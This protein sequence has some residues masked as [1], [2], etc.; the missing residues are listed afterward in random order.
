MALARHRQGA[1]LVLGRPARRQSGAD[2]AD[3]R[4]AQEAACSS[5]WSAW[6]SRRSRSAFPS[7]SQT[8]FDF[9]RSIIERTRSP[10]MSTIQVL[11]QCAAGTDR[12]HLRGGQGR[13]DGHRPLLQ[14]DLDLQRAWCSARTATGIDRHRRERRASRS[15]R[16]PTPMPGTEIVSSNIR[17]RA[18][19]AP[20]SI[21]RVEICE[22][23]M[24]VMAADAGEAADP[25][26]AGD[27]RDGDAE[28][29]R[30]PDRMVRRATSR[31]RDERDPVAS[32]RTTIAAPRSRRP[33]WR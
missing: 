25:Q 22:A 13:Q 33:S 18:S 15:R 23:V 11:T 27:G 10:T 14:L 4:R 24:D 28:H 12:A 6:A 7:A 30:R 5:C 32:I 16:W 29:L 21:S 8:D 31:D 1:D 26:P 17:P 9:V 19:P 3:G 2:R 20:N